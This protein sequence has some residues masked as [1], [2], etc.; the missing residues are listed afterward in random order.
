MIGRYRSTGDKSHI[1]LSYVTHF[2][3]D[4]K[5]MNSVFDLLKRYECYNPMILDRIQFVIVDDCSPLTYEIPPLDLNFT[6]LKIT[7]DISWNNP[8]ARNLGVVYAS[9][10]KVLMTD[11]DHEFPEQT[12]GYI[13]NRGECG[14]HFYRFYRW[15]AKTRPHP[16]VFL[17]SRARFLRFYGYDEE[18]AGHYGSDDYRFVKIQK[19]YGTRFIKI[20]RRYRCF[21]RKDIDLERSYHSLTRDL[22]YNRPIDQRKKQE[23]LTYG[24]NAGHSRIFLNFKWEILKENSRRINICRKR[25]PLWKH[26]WYWR[27]L[28]GYK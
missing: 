22:S 9:S 21:Q 18:F 16:N 5:D 2:Y 1:R 28:F 3:C 17:I 10:D 19:Y 24:P 8:G 23:I 20:N 25:R 6:W 15:G 14:R 11:I 26:L 27:W 4:Q 12:L 13:V 7:D